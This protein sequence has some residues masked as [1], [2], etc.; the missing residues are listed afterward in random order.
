MNAI[1][2]AAFIFIVITVT[3]F[4]MAGRRNKSNNIIPANTR[5]LLSDNVAFFKNLD[6]A[7]KDQFE[8][9][10][11]DFLSDV[12]IKGVEVVVDDLDRVLVAAGAIIPIFNF[13]DWRYSNISE[14]LLYKGTFNKEFDTDGTARNVLGMVGDGAMHRIMILSQ[15]SVRSSFKSATDGHNTVIHEFVHL[16]DKADGAT[17]GIPEYLLAQPNIV[18]WV[19]RMHQTIGIMKAKKHSD[20]NIY[21]AT[22]DAEF[23]A[24]VSEYFFER[25]GKLKENHP[26]IY[27]L[28]EEMFVPGKA[29][30]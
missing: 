19:K 21:G 16:L 9:R 4:Y 12:S 2:I 3:F 11:K 22:N 30:S 24:V 8:G 28:M 25:P 27:E 17:D 14:V 7:R 15:P 29:I 10:V 5:R 1:A 6:D 13:P 23:F 18:P 26:E 20:I